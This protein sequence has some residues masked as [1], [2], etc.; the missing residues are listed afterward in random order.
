[1][2]KTIGILLII[3]T[4]L[5]G[6]SAN[7]K[8]DDTSQRKEHAE[9][10]IQVMFTA[11]NE[12]L[13]NEDTISY[14]GL[15]VEEADEDSAAD[16]TEII[17]NW[18]E[19]VG[20]CFAVG[21]LEQSVESGVLTS[22]LGEAFMMEEKAEVKEVKQK[23]VEEETEVYTVKWTFGEEERESDIF[24]RYNEDNLIEEIKNL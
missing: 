16:S 5:M 9:K 14:I 17:K 23:Q 20:D 1:M 8:T 19:E 7:E 3:C 18:Q 22:Y 13:F 21:V 2:K 4:F 6:C 10:V 24:F 12:D 11:P 15:G